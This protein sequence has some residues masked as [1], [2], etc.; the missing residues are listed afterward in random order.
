MLR[1]NIVIFLLSLHLILIFLGSSLFDFGKVPLA[2]Q[3]S[4]ATYLALTGGHPY[5]FFSPDIPTQIIVKCYI[6]ETDG[7]ITMETF[8][9]KS[10]IFQLR[11]NYLFQLL[12]NAG[13]NETAARLAAHYCFRQHSNTRSVRVS[14]GKF[15]VPSIDEYKQ[16]KQ[17]S[18]SELY[19]QT[20]LHE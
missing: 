8:D 13:D 14:V 10:N 5:N 9:R 19:T 15:I 17:C 2:L 18:Y 6:T 1:K 20:Y 12:D 11:A 3:P 16:G 4:I 7:Q